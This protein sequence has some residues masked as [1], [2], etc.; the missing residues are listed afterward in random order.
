LNDPPAVLDASALLALL[1]N[2]PGAEVAA[3]RLSHCVMSAVN[4]SEVVAKLA[5]HGVPE[6]DLRAALDGLDLEVRDFNAEAA[7]AA[8]ELR[9]ATRKDGLSFGDRACLALAMQLGAVA[10]TADRAWAKLASQAP[11]VELIR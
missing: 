2:E 7:Y 6:G 4:L 1:Q 9:R 5:D 8:G 3:R 10:V 11:R